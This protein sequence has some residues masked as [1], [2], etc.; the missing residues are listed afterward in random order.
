MR[1]T[2][3]GLWYSIVNHRR[4]NDSRLAQVV[5]TLCAVVLALSMHAQASAAAVVVGADKFSSCTAVGA[6]STCNVF[7]TASS[8]SMLLLIA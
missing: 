3:A 1:A 6:T 8:C 7:W 4:D 5:G 2:A